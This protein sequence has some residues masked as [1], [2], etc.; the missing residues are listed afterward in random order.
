MAGSI[1]HNHNFCQ[2]VSYNIFCSIVATFGDYV[3]FKLLDQFV[4]GVFIEDYYII[5]TRQSTKHKLPV[6]LLVNGS[7]YTFEALN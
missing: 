3:R 7:V 1:R 6:L 2:V 4:G 5:N